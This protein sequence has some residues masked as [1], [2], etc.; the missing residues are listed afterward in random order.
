[1][2]KIV[3]ISMVKNE[4]DII[5]SF[6]RHHLNIVDEILICDHNSCDT[7]RSIIESIRDEGFPI[8]IY[9]EEQVEHQQ[10]KIMT[11]LMHKAA[12]VYNADIILPLDADEF[13][14]SADNNHDIKST[15][16]NLNVDTVYIINST[17]YFPCDSTNNNDLF[18]PWRHFYKSLSHQDKGKVIVG[19]EIPVKHNALLEQG[20]HDICI[21]KRKRKYIRYFEH[22]QIQIAHI[23]FRS[24]KQFL[25]KITVGWVSNTARHNKNF[26]E[27]YHW[28]D[29]FDK[30]KQGI[31]LTNNES[32]KILS[33]MD[34]DKNSME[35]CS[36]KS[37]CPYCNIKYDKKIS[38]DPFIN[39][40]H[41]SENL[42]TQYSTLK[43]EHNKFSIL[44][45][46]LISVSL[47]NV[48]F[49]IYRKLLGKKFNN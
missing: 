28:R 46:K 22:R 49:F 12:C 20:N 44:L 19:R 25:S 21:S 47:Y 48:N 31:L 24:Y 38:T 30:I 9:H 37:K 33:S 27:A 32:Y 35:I 5:E 34:F 3:L 23:P 13:I 17:I 2:N 7:T 40:L 45:K 41:A 6:I 1:M 26:N 16:Q 8:H 18:F 15:L 39:I 42:A 36:F 4:S 29:A 14:V 10:S 11:E 43:L